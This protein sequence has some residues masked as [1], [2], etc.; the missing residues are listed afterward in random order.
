MATVNLRPNGDATSV[1]PDWT[2]S[3]GSTIYELLDEDDTGSPPSDSSHI[4][5]TTEGTIATIEIEDFDNTG[6]ASI[7]SVQAVVRANVYERSKSYEFYVSIRNSSSTLWAAE[8]SGTLNSSGAWRTHTFTA[9]TTSTDGGSAWTYHDIDSLRMRIHLTDLTAG[10]T[11]RV[12]YA[13]F[14]VTYTT[15]AGYGNDVIGVDSSDISII[16]GI[17]TAD[18]SKVN[19]V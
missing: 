2:L 4:S 11:F 17:A 12:T 13:Y 7:D 5:T 6:V 3:A 14:I 10:G 15:A 9:R 19:G 16:N 8:S 18:I 1:D